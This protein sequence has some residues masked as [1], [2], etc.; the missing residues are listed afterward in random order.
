MPLNFCTPAVGRRYAL[1]ARAQEC[2]EPYLA[3]ARQI[4]WQE[5]LAP[6]C[7]AK[8]RA[9]EWD[10]AMYERAMQA[11]PMLY[12]GLIGMIVFGPPVRA[13]ASLWVEAG[14]WHW[15]I[16]QVRPCEFFPC[17]GRLNFF[18]VD[19]PDSIIHHN[20]YGNL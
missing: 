13:H 4:R 17:L 14:Y 8:P 19:V 1:P 2:G 10:G 9:G 12:G 3:H 18:P 11:R 20:S 16:E 15:P 7:K 6:C 5:N